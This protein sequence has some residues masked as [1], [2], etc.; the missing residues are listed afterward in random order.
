[1]SLRR[2]EGPGRGVVVLAVAV[3]GCACCLAVAHAASEDEQQ[4][5][6]FERP[7]ASAIKAELQGILADP[8]F[9]P[10]KTFTQWLAEK[11][12][13]W[14]RPRLPEGLGLILLMIVTI[15]CVVTLL[16]ILAH[17]VW[18]IAV[19]ARRHGRSASMR[20][21]RFRAGTEHELDYGQ[22]CERMR[23][24]AERGMFRDAVG[25]MMLALLRWLDGFDLVSFHHSKTNGDYV[26]EFPEANPSRQEFRQFVLAFDLIAYGGAECGPD[27]YGQMSSRFEQLLNHASEE[28]QV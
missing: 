26:H 6:R 1:M 28:P 8:H 18:T 7:T 27:A 23:G 20:G 3:L 4:S 9:A 25:V 16:A 2:F 10:R 11:L 13:S 5:A 15:W 14:E 22:L 12:S 19:M 17:L 24:L 21:P